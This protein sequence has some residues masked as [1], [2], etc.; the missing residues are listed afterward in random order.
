MSG[1]C[2]DSTLSPDVHI[3]VHGR[4]PS[5]VLDEI[6]KGNRKE[7]K[8]ERKVISRCSSPGFFQHQRRKEGIS[9]EGYVQVRAG[10]DDRD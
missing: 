6:S 7:K 1:N 5:L 10:I 2:Q 8:K 3:S 9:K 4:P